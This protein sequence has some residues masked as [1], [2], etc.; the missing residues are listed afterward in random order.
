[1]FNVG[2]S[3]IANQENAAYVL[4]QPDFVSSGPG[5][6]VLGT[7]QSL[8]ALDPEELATSCAKY[9]PGSGRLFVCDTNNNRI[10]IFGADFMPSWP[11]DIP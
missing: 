1:M 11:A 3:V 7:T 9:D 5:A 8:L 6:L 4:G 10:M 2:P